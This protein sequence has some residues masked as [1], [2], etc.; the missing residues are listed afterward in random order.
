MTIALLSTTC[1]TGGRNAIALLSTAL[2]NNGKIDDSVV[3]HNI[4]TN[5]KRVVRHN[6]AI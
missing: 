3:K 4:G 1:Y 5:D 2:L 6:T